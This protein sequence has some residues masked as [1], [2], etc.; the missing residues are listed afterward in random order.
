MSIP[1]IKIAIDASRSIDTIQ[2][3]GV[4]KVS[5]ELLKVISNQRSVIRDR[6]VKFVFYTPELIPWLPKESQRILNWPFKF[7]WTQIRLGWELIFHPP[8][9]MFFP[10]HAMPIIL[11]FTHYTLHITHYFKTIHD[12]AFK[13]NP[14]LYPLKQRIIL[15]LDLWLAIK[16]CQKIFMPTQA[17][18]DNILHYCHSAPRIDYGAG[19]DAEFR[20]RI[21]VVPHGYIRNQRNVTPTFRS[22]KKKQILYIG[23]IEEKKNIGNLIKAF[24]IFSQRYPDYKL[25]LAGK[26]KARYNHLQRQISVLNQRQSASIELLGYISDERKYEL[27]AE[28]ACLVL[29]SKEEGFGFPILEAF[30]FGL[31]VVASD[32]PVLREIGSDACLYVNPESPT[33]IAR[34]RPVPTNSKRTR[35][36]K[37]I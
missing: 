11:L 26:V 14:S 35:T 1:L 7:L 21:V 5:D 10:V 23:R 24:E 25:V 6:E 17:V 31:P 32:I 3:T 15:N 27:L 33:D 37:R 18:K 20:N 30:D 28:S 36:I 8:E 2:K 34:S 19:S 16:L 4:E 29:V 9:A 12:I 13:K 22:D